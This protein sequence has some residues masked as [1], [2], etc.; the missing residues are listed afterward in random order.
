MESWGAPSWMIDA[1]VGLEDVKRNGWAEATSPAVPEI[2]GRQP[3]TLASFLERNR[4]RLA[5]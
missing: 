4:D 5:A 2:L 3:E 1:L